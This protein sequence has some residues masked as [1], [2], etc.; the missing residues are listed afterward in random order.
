M[1]FTVYAQYKDVFYRARTKRFRSK[2]RALVTA[3]KMKKVFGNSYLEIF[4]KEGIWL[5]TVSL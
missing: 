1:F 5:E 4:D 3:W 2:D